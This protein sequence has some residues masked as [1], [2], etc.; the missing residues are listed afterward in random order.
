VMHEREADAI[1]A[2]TWRL[3][4]D[5]YPGFDPQRE[6]A[7]AIFAKHCIGCHILD[8]DGGNDGPNVSSIG[9]KHDRP[10]LRLR[11][12]DPEAVD[13]EAEMP[14]FGSRLTADELEAVAAY[15]ASRR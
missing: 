14:A 1:V 3:S 11:I 12:E 4:R 5:P 10:A 15:L 13:P 2:Y 7:A 8:G 6:Q 9:A